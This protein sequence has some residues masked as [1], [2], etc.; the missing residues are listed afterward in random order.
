MSDHSPREREREQRSGSRDRRGDGRGQSNSSERRGRSR[1]R[2]DR[3]N[4]DPETFTQIYVAKLSRR[5][6]D[7][8]LKDAFSKFGKIN[9]VV[10]KNAFA[11]IDYD[12]H[13]GAVLA[14]KE[15]NGK[16][17]VNGEELVCQE[18]REERQGHR[19]MMCAIIVKEAVIGKFIPVKEQLVITHIF[20]GGRM[21]ADTGEKV[22]IEE[23]LDLDLIDATEEIRNLI[24]IHGYSRSRSP[25]GGRRGG[26]RERSSSFR[27]G[28]GDSR[29]RDLKEGR[30][31]GCGKRGH[32]KRHCPELGG[33][34]SRSRSRGGGN[35]FRDTKRNGGGRHHSRSGSS[36]RSRGARDNKRRSHARS[37]SRGS[38]RRSPSRGARGSYSRNPE[39]GGE[40]PRSYHNGNDASMHGSK[41]SN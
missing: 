5:T 18:G 8:D 27:G 38:A 14:V 2:E 13:E 28:R 37:S 40:N 6:R 17:F 26:F 15:M 35:R 33:G 31:F 21:S 23:D 3:R 11:F 12:T 24:L 32:M 7:D 29:S 34:R 20:Y 10:L 39:R 4:K 36:S 30:C 16:T 41:L 25:R 19:T 9:Q 22:E 1:S